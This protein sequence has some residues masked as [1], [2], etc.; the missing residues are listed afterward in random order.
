V[1]N[2]DGGS[3]LIGG[4]ADL[5]ITEALPNSLRGE[6]VGPARVAAVG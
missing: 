3:E 2:F 4:F 1:V 5:R 6:L